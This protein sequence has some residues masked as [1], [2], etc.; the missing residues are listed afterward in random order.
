MYHARPTYHAGC[1]YEYRTNSSHLQLAEL[2]FSFVFLQKEYS[3]SHSFVLTCKTWTEHSE[4][5]RL[6]SQA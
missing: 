3:A 4:P 1:K 2:T 5:R 6:G